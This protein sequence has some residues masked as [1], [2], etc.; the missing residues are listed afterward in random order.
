MTPSTMNEKMRGSVSRCRRSHTNSFR[1]HANRSARPDIRSTR[2]AADL[3]HQLDGHWLVTLVIQ[4][5]RLAALGIVADHA[6]EGDHRAVLS[7]QQAVGDLAR[8]DGMPSQGEKMP[9]FGNLTP[10]VGAAA[11]GREEGDL[12]AVGEL[13]GRPGKLLVA[14]Q[15]DAAG[16]LPYPRKLAG[17][18]VEDA[19]QRG[20]VFQ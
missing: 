12:V 5:V 15:Q 6:F 13:R 3:G 20:A 1:M 17:V 9:V 10:R 4:E 2:F 19:A 8:D 11:D 14:C 16:H 18:V 7:A